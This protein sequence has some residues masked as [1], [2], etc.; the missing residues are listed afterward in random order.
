[1][2]LIIRLFFSLLVV[3]ISYLSYLLVLIII[4]K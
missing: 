3:F 4:N 1:M 2:A